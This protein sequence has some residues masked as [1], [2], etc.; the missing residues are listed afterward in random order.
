VINGGSEPT[1][2]MEGGMGVIN[3]LWGDGV[4]EAG[5]N[6]AATTL[7]VN[8]AATTLKGRLLSL[9]SGMQSNMQ[10]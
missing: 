8:P 3:G 2:G 5:V 1:V 10:L 4:R 6:P 9:L 7:K